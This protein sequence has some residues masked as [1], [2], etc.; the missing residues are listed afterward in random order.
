[1]REPLVVAVAQPPCVAHDVAANARAHAAA[2]RS[3]EAAGARV[4][5]FPE[6]S[7]TGYE[8]DADPVDPADERLQPMVEA[9]AATGTLAL[10]GAPVIIAPAPAAPS[11]DNSKKTPVF[12]GV[13]AVDARGAWVAYR[14]MWL[15]EDEAERF[16]PGPEPARLIVD[17]WRLGLAVCK[18][19]GVAQHAA[20]TAA[21]GIDAYLAGTVKHADEAGLQHE[22]A[23]RIAEQHHLWVA[24][25]SFAGPTGGGYAQTA[26]RSGIWAPDGTLVSETGPQ[27]GAISQGRLRAEP[28]AAEPHTVG[29]HTVGP[30]AA[31]TSR[32]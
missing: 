23:R 24:V 19:T 18:D 13:V 11:F 14:K 12:I 28:Q 7:L 9:C 32:D 16:T 27:P 25:A 4:V 10:A 6:L 3:P 21:L 8:L 31:A 20:D 2:I 29:P 30:Q 17:D 1:M 22:R 5:V 26:G 15:G